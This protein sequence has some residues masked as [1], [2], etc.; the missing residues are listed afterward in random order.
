MKSKVTIGILLAVVAGL[1]VLWLLPSSAPSYKGQS[2]STWIYQGYLD[3]NLKGDRR[4]AEEAVLAVGTNALPY[5]VKLLRTK[6]DSPLKLGIYRFLDDHPWL[7]MGVDIRRWAYSEGYS[8]AVGMVG[9][10]LLGPDAQPA[11]QDLCML[12]NSG[13]DDQ[14]GRIAQTLPE[15]GLVG[16]EPLTNLLVNPNPTRCVSVLMSLSHYAKPEYKWT[17]RKRRLPEDIES[18]GNAIVPALIPY[19]SNTDSNLQVSAIYTIGEFAQAPELIV[20]MI[21]RLLK[22]SHSDTRMRY[23]LLLALENYGSKAERA[24]PAVTEALQ[25]PDQYVRQEAAQ[26]LKRIAPRTADVNKHDLIE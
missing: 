21:I 19:L 2:I 26:A 22:S 6:R 8:R 4:Q 5:Y 11:I 25:D 13:D 17:Q 24:V 20:P 15:M 7:K 18:A 1:A 3:P 10:S 23:V 16:I 14:A 9:L 12:F